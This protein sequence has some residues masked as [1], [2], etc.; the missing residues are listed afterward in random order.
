MSA[1]IKPSALQR[2][3]VLYARREASNGLVIGLDDG[4]PFV[5][6]T[7]NGAVQRSAGGAPVAPGGW[8]HV[9]LVA[10]PG[11]VTLYLDGSLYSSLSATLP[12]LNSQL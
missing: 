9:A 8:H 12:A 6:V 4:A 10:T 7:V 3:A 5:E 1:W 2:N 11:L